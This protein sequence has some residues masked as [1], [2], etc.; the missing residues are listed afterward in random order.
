MDI[1]IVSDTTYGYRIKQLNLPYESM[2]SIE[3]EAIEVAVDLYYKHTSFWYQKPIISYEGLNI[4]WFMPGTS[5]QDNFDDLFYLYFVSSLLRVLIEKYQVS[6]IRCECDLDDIKK[7]VIGRICKKKEV[8]FEC[9]FFKKPNI[10]KIKND[11]KRS[12]FN[13]YINLLFRILQP[14]VKA[15]YKIL[16]TRIKYWFCLH[17]SKPHKLRYSSAPDLLKKRGEKIG[18]VFHGTDN[19]DSVK[20]LFR[21][22]GT[23]CVNW[24]ITP[25]ME[26]E[27][28]KEAE[29][30]KGKIDSYIKKQSFQ[31]S[32]PEFKYYLK[33]INQVSIDFLYK[34]LFFYKAYRQ[35]AKSCKN[36]FWFHARPINSPHSRVITG[37]VQSSRKKVCSVAPHFYSAKRLTNS[38]LKEEFSSENVRSLPSLF[39]V[40][41][42]ISREVLLK[43]FPKEHIYIFNKHPDANDYIDKEDSINFCIL[44]LLQMPDENIK[45]TTTLMEALKDIT[46]CH[47]QFKPHPSHPMDE[48][49]SSLIASKISFEILKPEESLEQCILKCDICISIYSTATFIAMKLGKPI[50]W[51]PFISYNY[52]FLEEIYQKVG[53]ISVDA[54][55]LNENIK[56]LMRNKSL[57][58]QEG[59]K[60]IKL[61]NEIFCEEQLS[62]QIIRMGENLS[63][64]SI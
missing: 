41:E 9:H 54:N 58:E 51:L 19:E 2:I 12:Y 25:K 26:K 32:E 3:R 50:I 49:C 6:I 11:Q 17:E 45:L 36:S 33:K 16:G 59:L 35:F 21:S 4:W 31:Q 24:F 47:I 18:F 22:P 37:A 29:I 52:L 64:G 46:G 7:E 48:V 57:Y 60:S 8:V 43:Y 56:K 27:L 61:Y 13:K 63:G 55:D 62:D 34:Y 28:K 10:Q 42:K 20:K 40:Q 38:F 44:V 39:M 14:F 1:D 23:V 30:L 5:R 53:M 15:Y